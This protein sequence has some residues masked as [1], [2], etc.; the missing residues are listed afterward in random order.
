[1]KI[2]D[3]IENKDPVETKSFVDYKVGDTESKDTTTGLENLAMPSKSIEDHLN[4][5]ATEILDT[6]KSSVPMVK[7]DDVVEKENDVVEKEGDTIDK[8][9]EDGK[10]IDCTSL[11][12]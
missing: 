9:R 10:I 1:M 7:A 12:L 4:N 11:T 8:T 3:N 2:D 6:S 5:H